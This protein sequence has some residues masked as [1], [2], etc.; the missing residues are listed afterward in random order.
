MKVVIRPATSG[1]KLILDLGSAT[2]LAFVGA[3]SGELHFHDLQIRG[4]YHFPLAS[5]GTVS[6]LASFHLNAGQ[7]IHLHNV[8][9]C[10]PETVCSAFSN[11]LRGTISSTEQVWDS[12][13]VASCL[14]E[15]DKAFQEAIDTFLYSEG[16]VF[17]QEWKP[18]TSTGSI[19]VHNT[20][21][22]CATECKS[23]AEPEPIPVVKVSTAD[24]RQ[25]L[26]AIGNLLYES[27]ELE[28]QLLGRVVIYEHKWSRTF[29]LP[30]ERS[31]TKASIDGLLENGNH[32]TLVFSIDDF[33]IRA[34]KGFSIQ[35]TNMVLEME[36]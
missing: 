17:P 21:T 20:T 15:R 8:T 26:A 11:D 5:S 29:W 4:A 34:F 31:G 23:S 25:V 27:Q 18:N 3:P 6:V 10:I 30:I 14:F 22:S 12:L 33:L 28:I 36:R 1:A 32:A 9:C 7:S 19:Y 13:G 24:S 2:D 16:C 35:L